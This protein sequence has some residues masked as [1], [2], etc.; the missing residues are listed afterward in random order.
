M[1]DERVD[2]LRRLDLWTRLQAGVALHAA[3]AVTLPEGDGGE[4]VLCGC[5][6]DAL[7]C[8]GEQP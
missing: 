5:L 1:T 3:K 6:E 8:A 7:R 2:E 4:A